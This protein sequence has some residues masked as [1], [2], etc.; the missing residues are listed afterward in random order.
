[1]TGEPRTSLAV[2]GRKKTYGA[3]YKTVIVTVLCKHGTYLNKYYFKI[4]L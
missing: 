1:M 3:N 4:Y 2:A